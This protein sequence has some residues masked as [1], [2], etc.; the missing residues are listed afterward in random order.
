M[1]DRQVAL[2]RF[3]LG[4]RAGD[5]NRIDDPVLFL[6]EQLETPE[7]LPQA[8]TDAGDLDRLYSATVSMRS[9]PMRFTQLSREAHRQQAQAYLEWLAVADQGFPLHSARKK[10]SL[11]RLRRWRICRDRPSPRRRSYP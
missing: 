4:S 8:L 1:H 2:S 11:V 5:S 3:G 10:S 7:P 6:K 9:D